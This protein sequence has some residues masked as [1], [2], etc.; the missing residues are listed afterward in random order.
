MQDVPVSITALQNSA[1][2]ELRIG[3]FQDYIM[4]LPNVVAQGTGPGQNELFIRGAATSQ[5]VLTLSS[6]QGLQP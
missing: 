4:F 2:E 6:V 5:T 3:T 1:L